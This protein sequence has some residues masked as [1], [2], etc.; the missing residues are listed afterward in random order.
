MS[1]KTST[2]KFDAP[3]VIETVLSAQFSPLPTYTDAH[4]G[5][6]WK[7][8]LSKDWTEAKAATRIDDSF[9]RFGDDR[10]W[11]KTGG[12][13]ISQGPQAQRFQI[14][15]SEAEQ[16]RMV[17]VQNSRFVYNWRRQPDKTENYPSY[18]TLLPEFRKNLEKFSAF[19]EEASL[20]SL[21]FNQWEVVYVNHIPRG[22]LWDTFNDW[23]SILPFFSFPPASGGENH[24]LDGLKNGW[25]FVIGENI[26]RLHISINQVR[27][28]LPTNVIGPEMME[29][30]FIARGPIDMERGVDLYSGLILDMIRLLTHLPQ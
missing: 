5:W 25:G 24:K 4:A 29:I 27:Q 23:P 13:N 21:D 16:D 2:P 15:R 14:I 1:E 28:V 8:Y 12:F 18:N 9:E 22:D 11:K 10:E 3:P 6:F 30:R 19:A 7:N 17:Q 20:G 26:G